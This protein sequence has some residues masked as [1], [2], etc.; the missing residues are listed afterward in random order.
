[1]MKRGI[2][3]QFGHHSQ[4]LALEQLQD[5]RGVG[6]IMSPRDLSFDNAQ[7]R[8][9]EYRG[10]GAEVLVDQQFYE[11]SFTNEHTGT[12]PTDVFRRS[13][14]SLRRVSEQEI[15]DLA[16][17]IEGINARVGASAIIAPAVCY[18]AGRVE[19][20]EVNASLFAAARKAGDALKVPVYAT[21]VLGSSV[22]AS[23]GTIATALDEATA[24]NSDGWYFGFE[25]N[26]E[27]IPSDAE[28]VLRCCKAGLKLACSGK[29][30]LHAFAGPSCLLSFCFG[31]TGSAI[32]HSQNLWQFSRSRWQ[33]PEGG[34]GGGAAPS[35]FFSSKLWGT[36]VYPDEI[37]RVDVALANALLTKTRFSQ[38]LSARAPF[39][40]FSRHES[41]KHLLAILCDSATPIAR[42]ASAQDACAAADAILADAVATHAR[43]QGAGV[44]L[45]D[46]TA[47]YQGS[48]RQALA[49]LQSESQQ[50]FEILGMLGL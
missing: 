17:K 46:A 2:W 6:V 37:A 12:Y 5:R 18:E 44:Q 48:W 39:A 31:A 23:A 33:Q 26:G 25:F 7:T 4:T 28:A 9:A 38:Q 47:S 14:S 42:L 32:G 34:G 3:H 45:L 8:A 20:A 41:Y 40:A 19:T 24:I 49:R 13:L 30:V 29:P 11:P 22:A 15:D 10:R 35:R 50:D 36:I 16:A 27:R 1:M 43:I 21:V